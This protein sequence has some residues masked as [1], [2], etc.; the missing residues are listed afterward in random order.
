M[1]QAVFCLHSL[2]I[3]YQTNTT[4]M[5]HRHQDRS[6]YF[7]EL[8]STCRRYFI[9]YLESHQ[10]L[11]GTKDVLEIG[12]G[13]G[14]NL[15]PFAQKGHRVSGI[16]IA[17]CRIRQAREFF[18]STPYQATFIASDIFR[19]AHLEHRFD[20]VICHDVFE[21]I[22]DKAGLL[23]CI[24]RFLKP[25]GF[26]LM[27]FP[28]WHMPFGGHQQICR[29]ALLSRLPFIHLLPLPLYQFLLKAG[30]ES[31]ACIRELTDIRQTGVTIELFERLL[32]QTPFSLIDRTL[33]LINPHY[34]TKFGLTPRI[35]PSYIAAIPYLRN[36]F[37]TSCF[38][39]LQPNPIPEQPLVPESS[40]ASGQSAC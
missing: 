37:C 12:C 16:D 8:A 28:A 36:F 25:Q 22:H 7:E 33:W 27:S 34:H 32:S 21:H 26:L 35:L 17:E 14:G 3:V 2:S 4:I 19:S 6:L 5:Q 1:L 18:R 40:T 20:L 11:Q 30:A 15:L 23:S 13:E 29:S 31:P 24:C 38:Y 10:A 9:P 39:L